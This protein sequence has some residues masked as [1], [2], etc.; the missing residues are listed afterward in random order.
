MSDSW[1]KRIPEPVAVAVRAPI[2]LGQFLKLANVVMDG[3]HAREVI[4][5]GLVTVDGELETR[6]G[7]QLQAGSVVLVT[8]GEP[9]HGIEAPVA[10]RVTSR[11]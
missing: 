5:S 1:L 6:R 10:L 4:A 8:P 2:K 7:R 9:Y 11:D 3:V